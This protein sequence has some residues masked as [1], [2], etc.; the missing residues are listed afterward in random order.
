M[1][2]S[3][4]IAVLPTGRLA[5]VSVFKRAKAYKEGD[6]EK[7]ETTVL[8][9]HKVSLKEFEAK[10]HAVAKAKWGEI[11]KKLKLPI[12]D[13]D[14]KDQT[15]FA[16]CNYVVAKTDYEVKCIDQDGAEIID[17]DEIYAGVHA[18]VSVEIAAYE[19]KN[20]KGQILGRGVKLYLRAIK[21][22]KDD[23]PFV[24]RVNA[25]EDF[26]DEAANDES[27]YQDEASDDGLDF[28]DDL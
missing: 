27:N 19:Q 18:K 11:P 12:R 21:K 6:K 26:N 22:V 14:E 24:Q 16:G 25:A 23:T 10:C 17:S 28:L 5:F 1:A 4:V 9:P 3:K 8:W 13:G 7:F 2:K 15:G 20:D